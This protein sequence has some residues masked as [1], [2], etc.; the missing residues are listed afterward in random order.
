MAAMSSSTSA[1]TKRRGLR[2]Q[3]GGMGFASFMLGEADN[4]GTNVV[5]R[6]QRWTSWYYAVFAQDDFKVTPTLTL[7]IGLR[8]DVDVPRKEAHNDTSNFSFTALDPES[9]CSGGTGVWADTCK[10]CN[11]SLGE[12]VDEGRGTTGRFRVV[13]GVSSSE[14]CVRGGGSGTLY[15]PLVYTDFGGGTV[16]GQTAN[17][18]APSHNGFD[19]SFEIDSGMP[20][21]TPPPN[22]DPGY[23]NGTYVPGSYI[24]KT[25]ARPATVYNWNL[26]VQHQLAEDLL[27]TVGYVGNRSTNLTSNL[28][29]PN[30]MSKSNFGLGDALYQSFNGN[31]AGVALPFPTF[32]QNWGRQPATPTGFAA[33]PAI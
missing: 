10:S 6:G 3:G 14:D 15:G 1:A 28:L 4:G 17:P 2:G 31:T 9:G 13:S 30:N 33:L 20:A 22:E 26:E 18:V 25:A 27:M 7:N 32:L 29:N 19:P 12:Y 21:F 24:A 11:P 5:L 16:T 8:Y 23:Y